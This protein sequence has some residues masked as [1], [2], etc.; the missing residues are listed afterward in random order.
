[1]NHDYSLEV[2]KSLQQQLASARSALV[3]SICL[4]FLLGIALGIIQ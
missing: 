1:M 4:N 2:I 3:I